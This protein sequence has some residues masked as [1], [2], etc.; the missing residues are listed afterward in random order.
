M[1]LELLCKQCG[2]LSRSEM[3]ISQTY[4][5]M[6]LVHQSDSRHSQALLNLIILY[7]DNSK[8]FLDVPESPCVLWR[9][10]PMVWNITYRIVKLWCRWY[11]CTSLWEY[12]KIGTLSSW[13]WFP[14]SRKPLCLSIWLLFTYLTHNY[15]KLHYIIIYNLFTLCLNAY[16]YVLS[17]WEHTVNMGYKKGTWL[18]QRIQHIDTPEG[19]NH[20]HVEMHFQIPIE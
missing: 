14:Q 11:L 3:L 18:Q 2:Q 9:E 17:T 20:V 8:V 15:K 10:F 16:D 12:C 13:Q 7:S 5:A 19:S 1:V 4:W 6:S